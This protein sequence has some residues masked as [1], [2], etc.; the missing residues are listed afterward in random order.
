MEVLIYVKKIEIKKILS[1]GGFNESI[2]VFPRSSIHI[3]I[4]LG[5]PLFQILGQWIFQ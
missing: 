4:H 5:N 1:H 3:A 2:H